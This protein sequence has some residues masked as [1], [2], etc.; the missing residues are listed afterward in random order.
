MDRR[1]HLPRWEVG[2]LALPLAHFLK[3]KAI[4]NNAANGTKKKEG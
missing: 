3:E 2:G 4:L 1:K